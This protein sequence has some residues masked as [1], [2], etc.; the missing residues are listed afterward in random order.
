MHAPKRFGGDMELFENPV[1]KGWDISNF[2][3]F[4]LLICVED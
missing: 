1:A 3:K 4:H 2:A